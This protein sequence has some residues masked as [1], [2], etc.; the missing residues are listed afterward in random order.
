MVGSLWM[1]GPDGPSALRAAKFR[2]HDSQNCPVRGVPQFGHGG[3]AAVPGDAIGAGPG[4][5][6]AAAGRPILIPHV[7]QK[8]VLAD[9]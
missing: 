2:P 9:S 1:G 6:P 3:P 8:S 5:A 4:G 7:S